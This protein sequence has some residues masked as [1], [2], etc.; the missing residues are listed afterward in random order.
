[1]TSIEDL[2]PEDREAASLL[3]RQAFGGT[4][5]F[6]PERP[7]VGEGRHVAAY[8]DGRLVGQVRRHAFQQH[9][10]G[11]RLTCAGISG[12]VV[13]PEARRQDLA[14]R[15]LTES[16]GR[17]DADGEVIAALYPT[18]AALYRSVGFEVAGWWAERSVPVG[19]LPHDDGSTT[20]ERADFDDPRAVTVYD[21]MA[22]DR[23]G[24]LDP[25]A[26]FWRWR[27]IHARKDDKA[28]RYLYI[29]LRDGEA[30]AAVQ[31]SY[32]TAERAMYRI[33]VEALHGVDGAAVRAGLAFVGANGTTAEEIRTVLPV[34]E[35]ELHLAHV[36]RTTVQRDWPWMLAFVDLAGAIAARGYPEGVAGSVP[37][38]VHDPHRPANQGAWVLSVADGGATLERGGE[39][40]VAVTA[41]DLAAVFSGH[42]DPLHLARSDRLGHPSP[43][44]LG[45]LRA[46]FAG[47][48]SLTI[49]F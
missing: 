21:R 43:R 9:F 40:R 2:H 7:G 16:L 10:G 19:E 20:W 47:H 30:V 22:A 49:F 15:M 41:R 26:D 1:V 25:G 31:Y 14:R 45:L 46:A 24:W 4:E 42:L 35:L 23:D 34:D 37:L 13:A 17:A 33:D 48:P 44:D 3:G 8:R 6:D 12:V 32:G 38:A 27:A 11:R 28:N 5:P 29:G 36:Q 39:G 18:T